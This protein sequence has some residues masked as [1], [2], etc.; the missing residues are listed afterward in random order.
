MS[1]HAGISSSNR[2]IYD[3]CATQQYYYESTSPLKYRL[4][5]G[6][7]ENCNKCTHKGQF[8]TPYELVDIES[9]LR[10]QTRPA[11][12]CSNF[13]Y[14]PQCRMGKSANISL[15]RSTFDKSNPVVMAPEICPIVSNNI[16]RWKHPGYTLTDPRKFCGGKSILSKLN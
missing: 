10:N 7:Q 13:S 9:E 12:K 1:G 14:N 11:S 2:L 16:R 3:N 8:W 4:Y 6:A 5:H 15:C